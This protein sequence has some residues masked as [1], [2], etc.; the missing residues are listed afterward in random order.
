[1]DSPKLKD[2]H[3]SVG[4][5][6]PSCPVRPGIPYGGGLVGTCGALL[7]VLW[8]K[9]IPIKESCQAISLF[10]LLMPL[11]HTSF[12]GAAYAVIEE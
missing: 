9:H 2:I 6:Y 10:D 5:G 12:V 3:I 7:S 4:L 1:M 8:R 11:N